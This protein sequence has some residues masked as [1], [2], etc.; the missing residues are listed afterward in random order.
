[1]RPGALKPNAAYRS[2]PF[3]RLQSP[4]K[5]WRFPIVVAP[6]RATGITW[7]Y[8]KS[9]LLPHWA[10]LPPSRSKT[11]RRTSRG[12]GLTSGPGSR[13]PAFLHVEQHVRPVQPLRRPAS[14]VPDQ[15]QHV[16]FPVATRLPVER[17]LEP[18][19]DPAA[20]LGHRYRLVVLRGAELPV[21]HRGTRTGGQHVPASQKRRR[22]RNPRSRMNPTFGSCR[23][24]TL[25]D[26][27]A[28][29]A[30]ADVAGAS[31]VSSDSPADG[32]KT[33]T[34]I[35][36]RSPNAAIG[37]LSGRKVRRRRAS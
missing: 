16:P 3:A 33:T 4:D 28:R 19:P 11:V 2:A 20:E 9:K 23:N 10:H 1:L 17:V 25:P 27:A 15:G 13:R 31:L 18:P 7:S 24:C 37:F 26:V 29:R 21:L 6:P 36:I 14:P 22:N 32:M 5:S 12:N 8:C 34:M 30:N 35:A